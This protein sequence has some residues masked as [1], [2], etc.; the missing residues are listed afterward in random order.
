MVD[1]G[2]AAGSAQ[3]EDLQTLYQAETGVTSG[4]LA[5]VMEVRRM[6]GQKWMATG[7]QDQMGLNR[8]THSASYYAA[9]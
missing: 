5:A 6:H 7:T 1:D 8:C 3:R 9:D 2:A 4:H